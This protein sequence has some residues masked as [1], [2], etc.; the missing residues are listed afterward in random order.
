MSVEFYTVPQ[1]Q[2]ATSTRPVLLILVFI[3]I[4]ACGI[5]NAETQTER[6]RVRYRSSDRIYVEGGKSQGLV[7]GTLLTVSG[8]DS[9][10]VRLKVV[11]ASDRSASCIVISGAEKIER[12]D[13]LQVVE[14]GKSP[15]VAP[16]E[17][18]SETVT[19]NEPAHSPEIAAEPARSTRSGLT[20]RTSGSV[21]LQWYSWQDNTAAD[22]D[23]DQSTLRLHFRAEDIGG[24][25]WAVRIRS[26]GQYDQRNRDYG[27]GAPD[28]EFVN[29][30]YEASLKY[31]ADE[32]NL[33]FQLGR[34]LPRRLS[35]VGYVDGA[36]VDFRMAEAWH[37]GVLAG[38]KPRWQFRDEQMTFQKYGTY[39]GFERGSYSTTFLEQY[40]AFAG[41]Y[42]GSEISREFFHLRGRVQS[43]AGWSI[44]HQ[45]DVDLNRGWR[46]D[47]ADSR[48]EI[49]N[50]YLSARHKLSRVLSVTATYDSRQNYWT[51]EQQSTAD[52]LFDDELRR[53]VRGSVHLRLP[54]QLN[55]HTQIGY[56][57]NSGGGAG[58][59]SHSTY[60]SKS[61]L[62]TPRSMLSVRFSGFNGPV[63]DG[64]SYAIRVNQDI[65]RTI[66][67]AAGYGA[68]SYTA[69]SIDQERISRWWEG[70]IRVDLPYALFAHGRYQHSYGDDLD[71][72]T[73]QVELGKRF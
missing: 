49:T 17:A 2:P 55:L 23:F 9:A 44:S 43:G 66:I 31:G 1:R 41:E 58:T 32:S 47:K 18:D 38:A 27:T 12:G 25:P 70:S 36:T 20:A 15:E 35:R 52:S 57:D 5:I 13:W 50:L 28:N 63:N 48:V 45:M 26:R 67:L 33:E 42:R 30:L 73:L 21:S 19:V 22:L 64:Y 53:G 51:Y 29:R 24:R 16:V 14:W 56:R 40:F 3:L 39:L 72:N 60:L 54:Y 11:Y 34:I 65:R 46:L 68:Y 61:N 10:R 59:V 7:E 69:Q 4:A 37:V 62:L 6:F 71:G 8:P